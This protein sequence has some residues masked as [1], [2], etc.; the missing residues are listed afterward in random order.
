MDWLLE[1][2]GSLGFPVG[3]GEYTWAFE[4]YRC[5]EGIGVKGTF[6]FKDF[7][8]WHIK[9]FENS[10]EPKHKLIVKEF[11]N[12]KNKFNPIF[13]RLGSVTIDGIT[14]CGN[15][16]YRKEWEVDFEEAEEYLEELEEESEG[17]EYEIFKPLFEQFREWLQDKVTNTQEK[18]EKW[19]KEDIE[20]R[21]SDEGI[22]ENFETNEYE[23][24][25]NGERA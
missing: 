14:D 20:S 19:M 8:D 6:F 21:L 24:L 5:V 17:L 22:I 4:G 1:D 7:I 10:K 9:N 11:T 2:I 12:I 3:K 15:Q 23:F 13:N 16:W 18:Y 25:E